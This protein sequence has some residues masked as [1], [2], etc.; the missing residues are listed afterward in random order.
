[1]F[2]RN[3]LLALG[4]LCVLGGGIVLFTSTH[5]VQK[6]PDAVQ[7]RVETRVSVVTAAKAI[8]KGAL[9][10]EDDLKSKELGPNEHLQPGSIASGQEN[11]FLGALSRRDFTE[12]EPL[13]ASEF[14]KTSDRKSLAAE[15]K[16]GYRAIT[17][18]VDAA[19]SLAGLALQRDYVD[20]ILI[21]SF[22]DTIDLRHRTVGETVLHGV[23]VIALDQ[24]LTRRTELSPP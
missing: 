2:V 15:L 16:P 17:I 11:E 10:R 14:I 4:V 22:G 8:P 6:A 19:Q 3:I 7:P 13:I 18:P 20:V 1:M 5:R 21:Q 24:S 9:L 23:R 12:G